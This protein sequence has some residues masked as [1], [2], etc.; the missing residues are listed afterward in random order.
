[1]NSK[2][3]I[4][5]ASRFVIIVLSILAQIVMMMGLFFVLGRKFAWVEIVLNIT[6]ALLFLYLVNK[7][8]PAV[9]K[10]PWLIL[11]LLFP[12]CGIILYFTFGNVK[13]TKKQ[14]KRYRKIYDERHDG[15]Y[16]QSEVLKNMEE[17]NAKGLP[18]VKYLLSGAA[19]I[20]PETEAVG[21]IIQLSSV[22]EI[23]IFFS[24]PS[25]LKISFLSRWFG[26]QG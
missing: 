17:D 10:L 13:L 6:G 16:R 3:T 5:F 21:I 26:Q 4:V 23:P 14:L 7:D 2:K 11:I 22:S 9:F 19:N 20:I 1:M 24:T 8:Q 25:M 18:I 12:L 15:Y